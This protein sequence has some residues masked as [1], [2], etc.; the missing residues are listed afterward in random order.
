MDKRLLQD[1]LDKY[2]AGRC[3]EEECQFLEEY[4]QYFQKSNDWKEAELGNKVK[5]ESQLLKGINKRISKTERKVLPTSV[6]LKIAASVIILIA[7]GIFTYR[8]GFEFG[9]DPGLIYI[10]KATQNGQKST[11]ILADGTQI[12]LNAGSKL[13]YPEQFGS[14][15][16]IVTLYGE[17]FFE[18]VRDENRPFIVKSKGLMTKVLGTSFNVKAFDNEHT[19]VTVRTG[20]VSVVCG[21]K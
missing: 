10:E 6:W 14:D 18:V 2:L 13:K 7:A 3:S 11:I 1:L 4:Y 17:A 16:R 15:Q 5:L 20:R 12:K 19:Q 21:Y 8:F 9:G